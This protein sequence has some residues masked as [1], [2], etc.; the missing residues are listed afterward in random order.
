MSSSTDDDAEDSIR[1]AQA[2]EPEAIAALIRR[3]QGEL[4]RYV[5]RKAGSLVLKRE[6][7]DDLVQSSIREVLQALPKI[8]FEGGEQGFKAWLF[9][10]ALRKVLDR[11]RFYRRKRRDIGREAPAGTESSSGWSLDQ[12]EYLRTRVLSPSEAVVHRE[13]LERLAAAIDALPEMQRRALVLAYFDGC[14]HR[15]IAARLDRTETAVRS[16]VSR[17]LARLARLLLAE[18]GSD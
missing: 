1:R 13:D 16:L 11:Q 15:E 2:G 10:A 17:A 3:Y 6:S 18:P 5:A 14:P 12:L 9:K 7:E 8:E 4:A